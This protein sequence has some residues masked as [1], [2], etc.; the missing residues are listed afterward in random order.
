MLGTRAS[1]A[2]KVL[3]ACADS[4]ASLERVGR[5]VRLVHPVSFWFGSSVPL[6][7]PP[8]RICAMPLLSCDAADCSVNATLPLEQICLLTIQRQT[9]G[10]N[11]QNGANGP[12]GYNGRPGRPGKKG[13]AG[14]PGPKGPR[15][16][17]GAKGP[18]GDQGPR[19]QPGPQG[20]P[21]LPGP[22]GFNA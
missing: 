20:P 3:Q 4:P 16:D 21:G 9:A 8:V 2:L 14:Y 19:G 6:R 1:K 22:R 10:T 17:A 13:A 12:P 5:P 15:G 11:G 18:T 7:W